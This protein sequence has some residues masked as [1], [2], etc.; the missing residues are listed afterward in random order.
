MK[1]IKKSLFTLFFLTPSLFACEGQLV[2]DIFKLIAFKAINT[3]QSETQNNYRKNQD[4]LDLKS[5]YKKAFSDAEYC[6]NTQMGENMMLEANDKKKFCKLKQTDPGNQALAGTQTYDIL[7]GKSHVM[8][9]SCKVSFDKLAKKYAKRIINQ[10]NHKICSAYFKNK[11][12][13]K[14]IKH[15]FKNQAS[16][17]SASSPNGFSGP[18]FSN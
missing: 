8:L 17:K 15:C 5:G 13:E 7:N 3:I 10:P 12:F 6:K 4:S 14:A 11:I 16:R 18:V 2:E 9:E 1:I